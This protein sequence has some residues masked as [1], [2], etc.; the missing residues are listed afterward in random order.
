[1]TGALN[2]SEVIQGTSAGISATWQAKRERS[3]NSPE[4]ELCNLQAE[5]AQQR[6]RVERK[7]AEAEAAKNAAVIWD[8]AKDAPEDHPYL[9]RKGI[10]ALA[11]RLYR[12]DFE[13]AGM[14]CDGALITKM[15]DET[16]ALHS[17]R[18][19]APSGEERF[20]PGGRVRGCY[21]SITKS[22]PDRLLCIAEG[23]ATGASV[24][25]A[26]GYP[27][28]VAFAGENLL[29]VARA[30]RAKYSA[31]Q[32]IVCAEGNVGIARATEAARATGGLLAVPEGATDFSELARNQGKEAVERAL[33]N[34]Q[35]P[36]GIVERRKRESPPE[37]KSN[38]TVAGE[39]WP[40]PLPLAAKIDSHPYPID[41]LPDTIRAA[42][43]E[44]QA[45]TKA[46]IPLV[47]SSALGALS[48]SSQAHADVRRA[49]KLTGPT[50]LF[51]LTISDSGER[52]STCDSFFTAAIRAY[53][54]RQ[55]EEGKPKQAEH[56]A[57]LTAWE[58]KRAGLT[59]AIK[60][61]ARKGTDTG[62][63]EK[64]LRSLEDEKPEA[65]RVPKLLRGDDTPENLAWVLS[66]EWPS[67]GAVSAEAGIVF[68]AHGMGKDSIMRNL[69]LLNILW[70]GGTLSIGR[71]TS[72][73]FSV[74]GARLTVALQVQEATL[75]SFFDR[76]GGL[77]RGTGFLARFL[78][79]WPEST[80][81]FRAFT[82][83]PE[84]WPALATFNRRIAAILE[85]PA[86]TNEEG[87]LSPPLLPLGPE[88]KAAWIAYHDAIEGELRTG[89]ELYDVRDV[90]SKSADN[91]AR[92]AAL[93]Q[94]FEHG[95]GGAVG[96]KAFESAS[97]IAAWHLN[98]SR[99]FFGE[100]AL[101][102]ELANAARL[103]AWLVDYCRRGRTHIVPR[104]EVQR[105]G[106]SG[107]RTKAALA[108]ALREL[109][110]AGRV[111]EVHEVRRRD[112]LVNPALIG[113]G[114]I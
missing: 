54:E 11:L 30:L 53:Q 94:V 10:K 22:K 96:L 17:L 4:R 70:D 5:E 9:V 105:C 112:I 27:V 77:A 113:L 68:G 102:S 33:A 46:P 85:E 80:Q 88:A 62:S 83:P 101:P 106:P 41:K 14:P 28:A 45:F 39:G 63:Q 43:I 73:S 93:F 57:K 86:P 109:A 114:P 84:S 76:S 61:G 15:A 13:I 44:V 42:V 100:L 12:G 1:M 24:H 16:E 47:A 25:E 37:A 67:A 111:R 20:L 18:F 19:I 75:R 98:E 79:A 65:P 110:D 50:S 59:E 56:R 87:A 60:Q 48:L 97:P 91:A 29:P 92:L 99:R 64:Q 55:A 58:A 8:S 104:R 35:K 3:M 74:R 72:E 26:T 7:A 52:K 2:P 81:G 71:R 89:G 66:R 78:V 90:A 82:E 103:D 95:L 51:L 21:F 36:E 108:E 40:E 32:L 69:A 107:L 38:G 6:A 31:A 23:F 49:E 34:A